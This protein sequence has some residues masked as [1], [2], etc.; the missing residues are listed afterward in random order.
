MTEDVTEIFVVVVEGVMQGP[1]VWETEAAASSYAE[2]RNRLDK[3][4]AGHQWFRGCVARL[5][6]DHG[7]GA[8]LHAMK[9]MQK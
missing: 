3:L 5:V 1:I 6:F 9:G 7:N 8:V 2:A 4:T